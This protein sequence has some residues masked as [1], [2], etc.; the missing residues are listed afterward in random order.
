[1]TNKRWD[2]SAWVDCTTKKRWDGSTWV[3]LTVA[4]RWDGSTW[5]DFLGGGGS[6]L[7]A[8]VAPGTAMG[9]V[10]NSS[11]FSVVTSNSVTV[12]AT[13]GT[14]PYTYLWTFVSGDSAPQPSSRTTASV[15]FSATVARDSEYHSVWQCT[16]TDAAA[17]T[18]T[19]TVSVDLY[20]NST[21]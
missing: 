21:L 1:M 14:G 20:H 5:V 11:L 7:A 13:G 19:I 10:T 17:A 8:T 18:R 4:K 9:S 12:T 3:D 6:G 2:G 15:S 16:I